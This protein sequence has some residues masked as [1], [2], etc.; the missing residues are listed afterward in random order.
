MTRRA[1]VALII[2]ILIIGVTITYI[3][4]I[5]RPPEP[6]DTT[7]PSVTITNPEA[8]EVL[9]GII[10]I[11]FTATDESPLSSFGIFIDEQL[12]SSS[13]Q[14]SWNTSLESD[15]I[16]TITC[17]AQ[18][19]FDNWGEDGIT[20]TT[21]NTPP[22]LINNPPIVTITSPLDQQAVSGTVTIGVTITDED[23]LVANIYINES[24][25]VSSNSYSWDTTGYDNGSYT[26][27][28]ETIDSGALTGAATIQV[29]V[30]NIP[31]VPPPIYKGALKIMT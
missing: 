1:A 4:L 23:S 16:H 13:H 28:A 22:V 3:L 11:T 30:S 10:A 17:R 29:T 5:D 15:G 18:D 24:F 26:I 31:P 12:R 19:S 7:P 14:Y 2:L 6:T 21:N 27:R 25:I 8:E 20:V 9:S